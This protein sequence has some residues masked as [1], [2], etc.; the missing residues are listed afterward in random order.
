MPSKNEIDSLVEKEL[1]VRK[2]KVLFSLP[3]QLE[4]TSGDIHNLPFSERIK[5]LDKIP[6]SEH[7]KKTKRILCHSEAEVRKAIK[8]V[9]KEEGSEGAYLK[10]SNFLYELDGKTLNNIKFKNELSCEVQ[11]VKVNIVKERK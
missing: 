7:V 5:L 1:T 4:T 2:S 8:K 11:I 3:Q 10:L 6:E 9:S